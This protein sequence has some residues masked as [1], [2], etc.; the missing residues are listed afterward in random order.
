[1]SGSY[2]SFTALTLFTDTC[3]LYTIVTVGS[4]ALTQNR[5]S[6]KR[7]LHLPKSKLIPSHERGGGYKRLL[8]GLLFWS[9]GFGFEI[10][11]PPLLVVASRGLHRRQWVRLLG[12]LRGWYIICRSKYIQPTSSALGWHDSVVLVVVKFIEYIHIL[13]NM[14]YTYYTSHQGSKA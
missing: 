12:R 2:L 9:Y 1:M 14:K 8:L 11:E 7:E 10:L 13:R 4:S 5:F 6:Q 3:M